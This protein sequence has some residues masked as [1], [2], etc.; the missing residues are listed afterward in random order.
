MRL[1]RPTRLV[2]SWLAILAVLMAALAPAITQALPDPGTPVAVEVCTA[3]GAQWLDVTSSGDPTPSPGLGHAL[4]HCPYCSLH[5]DA[6]VLPVMPGAV[7]ALPR[8]QAAPALLPA[9]VPSADRPWTC[10]QPRAPPRPA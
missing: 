3:Q 2:S 1:R 4:H 8:P 9:E 10:A 7:P 6:L 5:A